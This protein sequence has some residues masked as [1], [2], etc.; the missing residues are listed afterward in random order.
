MANGDTCPM[1][2]LNA[3]PGINSDDDDNIVRLTQLAHVA[4]LVP[5]ARVFVGKTYSDHLNI[6]ALNN[7]L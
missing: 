7:T 6:P 3:Y 1:S 4:T 5:M 2:V